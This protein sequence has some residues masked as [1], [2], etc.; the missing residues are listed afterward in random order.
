M[1][2]PYPWVFHVM[3]GD[4]WGWRGDRMGSLGWVGGIEWNLGRTISPAPL[5]AHKSLFSLPSSHLSSTTY[6]IPHLHSHG[7]KY[8]IQQQPKRHSASGYSDS[9]AHQYEHYL[10]H[11]LF[12]TRKALFHSP[13]SP[14]RVVITASRPTLD[15]ASNTF[16]REA[17]FIC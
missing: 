5:P 11:S 13:F 15:C 3:R 17:I 12:F 14:S 1:Y 6:F 4:G 9:P 10:N 16:S 8:L 2:C 7:S